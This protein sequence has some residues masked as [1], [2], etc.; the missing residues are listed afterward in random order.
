VEQLN[1]LL[2]DLLTRGVLVASVAPVYSSLERQFRE[3]VVENGPATD[4][5]E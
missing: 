4:N 3:A 2:L 5:H 1:R